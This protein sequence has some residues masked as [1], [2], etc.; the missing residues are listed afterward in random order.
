MEHCLLHTTGCTL[1]VFVVGGQCRPRPEVCPLGTAFCFEVGVLHVHHMCIPQPGASH[2]H[3]PCIV[4][5]YLCMY[6]CT[7]VPID[8]Y[9]KG[10][11]RIEL[12]N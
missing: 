2:C 8:N 4:V 10:T 11:C 7:F 3:L 6:I 9:L 1:E 5:T 12:F